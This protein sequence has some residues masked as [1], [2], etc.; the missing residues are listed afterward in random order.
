MNLDVNQK[1]YLSFIGYLDFFK[2]PTS[3]LSSSKKIVTSTRPADLNR[4]SLCKLE[5]ELPKARWASD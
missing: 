4:S 5:L 2:L 3:H 1:I